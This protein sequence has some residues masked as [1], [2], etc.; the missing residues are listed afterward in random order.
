MPTIRVTG[1]DGQQYDV[2]YSVVTSPTVTITSV[3]PIAGLPPPPPPA[4]PPPPPATGWPNSSNTG[5]PA[6]TILTVRSGDFATTAAGQIV[7]ALD[8]RGTIIVLHANVT[9]KRC[10]A[11]QIIDAG[12]NFSDGRTTSSGMIIQDC[13]LNP[14]GAAGNTA[15]TLWGS[16]NC[17]L[18]RNNISNCEN[19]IWLEGSSN[20]IQDN[21]FHNFIPYNAVTDPHIDGIQIPGGSNI[22]NC[23]IRHNNLDLTPAGQPSYVS[24]SITMAGAKNISIDNNR[25]NGGTYCIYF[26]G[27]TSGCHVTNNLFVL[28]Q[29]GA[30]DGANNAAQTYSGNVDAA[31]HPI[32]G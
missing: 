29:F 8:V 14:Q 20:L 31:G 28:W 18:L 32:T 11:L 24:S 19:G 2:T 21:W 9:V 22:Q 23:V 13:T 10:K 25:L 6:G 30:I 15:I 16:I 27:G 1:T 26:E 7:D 4:Q 3:V 12:Q 17:Q 5:V